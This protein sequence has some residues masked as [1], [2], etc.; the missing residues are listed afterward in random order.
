MTLK[1]FEIINLTI[2]AFVGGMYWG[3][4]LALSRSLD[5][6]EPAA[7]LSVVQRLNNNMAPLMTALSPLSILTTTAVT[8]W[9]WINHNHISFYLVLFGLFMLVAAVVVTVT[10]EVSIV[11]RIITWTITTLPDDWK[12]QRDKWQRNHISRVL[13]GLGGL[14]LFL[15]AAIL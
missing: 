13:S 2:V 14:V 3:P 4:W 8:V 5:K 7:F 1:I 15:C 12:Q 10:I 11:K 6:F 9:Y